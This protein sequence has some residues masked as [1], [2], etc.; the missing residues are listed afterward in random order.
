[1]NTLILGVGNI[2]LSDEAV[3]VRVVETLEK[4]FTF[5]DGVELADGGTAG[6]ELL[7]MIASREHLILVDAVL[8]GAPPGTVITMSG[9]EIPIFFNNKVSPHQ[10]GLADLL[11]ALKLTD[12]SP[13]NLFLVGVV[14]ESVSPG[15]EMTQTITDACEQMQQHVLN[16]LKDMDVV[17]QR[18]TD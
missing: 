1:M 15:L 2:L 7:D 5:P 9:D 18:R 3:G 17:P 11:S 13:K 6:M 8:T 14:P 10:L 16:Y 12:E 4:Q